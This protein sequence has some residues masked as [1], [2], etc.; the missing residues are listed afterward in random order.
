MSVDFRIDALGLR[1]YR[2]H[3]RGVGLASRE[4]LRELLREASEAVGPHRF[5]PHLLLTEW[6]QV[7]DG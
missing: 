2:T 6:E 7:V 5:S 3:R 4:E 1:L